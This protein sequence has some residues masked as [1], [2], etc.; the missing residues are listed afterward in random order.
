MSDEELDRAVS[1]TRASVARN[2]IKQK[3]WETVQGNKPTKEQ[4]DKGA[5]VAAQA[6]YD[7]KETIA[8]V[9]HDNRD[10]IAEAAYD[11]HEYAYDQYMKKNPQGN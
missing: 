4:V 9:A 5:E 11:H 7:N 3:A 2:T 1:V 6:A 10:A 8:A